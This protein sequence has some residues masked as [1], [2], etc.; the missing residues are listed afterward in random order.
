MSEWLELTELKTMLR[1]LADEARLNIVH[2]LAGLGEVN[3]TEICQA[4]NISQPLVSW[5]LTMLRRA[6]LVRRRRRGRQ[7]YCSLDRARFQRCQEWLA[8][9]AKSTGAPETATLELQGEPVQP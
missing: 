2:H 4:L 8:S 7:A 3:V 1:A 5:H 6:G 9:L